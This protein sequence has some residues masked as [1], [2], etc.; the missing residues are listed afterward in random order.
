MADLVDRIVIFDCS[1]ADCVKISWTGSF[2]VSGDDRKG[3]DRAI[4]FRAEAA[5]VFIHP[6]REMPVSEI[7]DLIMK[8]R[9]TFGIV[10]FGYLD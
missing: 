1:T 6:V 7:L 10:L 8:Q 9:K 3:D 5:I 4:E 2:L